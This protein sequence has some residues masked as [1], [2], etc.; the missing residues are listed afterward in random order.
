MQSALEAQGYN[1][2]QSAFGWFN[3]LEMRARDIRS[4]AC[5][6]SLI[7]TGRRVLPR[8]RCRRFAAPPQTC[9]YAHDQRAHR[10]LPAPQRP[11]WRHADW[12]RRASIRDAPAHKAHRPTEV[13][14][15]LRS[16]ENAVLQSV[17]VLWSRE[18]V[19]RRSGDCTATKT[20]N[21]SGVQDSASAH[22]RRCCTAPVDGVGRTNV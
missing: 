15:V 13:D 9:W 21:G 16:V 4:R 3:R 8:K 17:S 18:L 11:R 1:V 6:P 7:A 19:I 14:D 2:Q 12:P 5:P 10:L 22:G 20:R